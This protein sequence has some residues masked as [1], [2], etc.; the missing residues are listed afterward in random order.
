MK[1]AGK[2][3]RFQLYRLLRGFEYVYCLG[4][5]FATLYPLLCL[6]MIRLFA[7]PDAPHE[8]RR[9]ALFGM[10]FGVCLMVVF[11]GRPRAALASM[12]HITA[13][14]ELDDVLDDLNSPDT[15]FIENAVTVS[16]ERQQSN[17]IGKR[18]L[19][20]FTSG[21]LLHFYQ[22]KGITV[23]KDVSGVRL[24]VTDKKGA[25]LTLVSTP[26]EGADAVEKC[27]DLI[28]KRYPGCPAVKRI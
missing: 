16:S 12:K 27:V 11:G 1:T 19:Y 23:S 18:Y 21:R 17:A 10:V 5:F 24:I 25:S 14:D 15:Q 8:W 2:I 4:A 13:Y 22:I 20:I 6:A 26:Y 28:R 3:G 7:P 9:M